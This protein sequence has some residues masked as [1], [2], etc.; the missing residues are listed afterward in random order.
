MQEP[1]HIRKT[2]VIGGLVFS[3]VGLCWLLSLSYHPPGYLLR[4]GFISAVLAVMAAFIF[5]W[6]VTIAYLARRRS[7]SP[8]TCELAGL[9]FVVPAAYFFLVSDSPRVMVIC[10]LL[11]GPASLTGNL[12]RHL[13]FPQLSDD[14]FASQ[15]PPRLF[16]K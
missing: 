12:C 6:A 4:F 1:T 16:P 11:L 5:S 8:R 2:L 3:F 7:W 15:S 9:V 10:G 13:A 14:E